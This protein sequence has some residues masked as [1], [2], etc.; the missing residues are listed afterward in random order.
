AA[1]FDAF[2]IYV[3]GER[4]NAVVEE[5]GPV[6]GDDLI[7]IADEL[8]EVIRNDERAGVATF[9]EEDVL[10]VIERFF[11]V[12][13]LADGGVDVEPEEFALLV[14]V[15]AATPVGPGR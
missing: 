4:G 5:R 9:A 6:V 12:G 10:E 8:I 15:L 2:E 1:L 11:V 13:E 14:V 7:E 3:R